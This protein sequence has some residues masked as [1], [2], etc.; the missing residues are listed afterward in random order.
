MCVSTTH[1][2]QESSV[3]VKALKKIAQKV[4]WNETIGARFALGR[5]I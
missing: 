4:R 3:L 1:I 5:H 2:I